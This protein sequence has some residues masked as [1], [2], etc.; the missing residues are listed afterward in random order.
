V[1]NLNTNISSYLDTSGACNIK[2]FTAVIVAV[3]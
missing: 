2:L 1:N 3:T